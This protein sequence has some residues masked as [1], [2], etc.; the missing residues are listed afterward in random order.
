MNEE[1]K[2][3]RVL[4]IDDNPDD[5]QLVRREV[6]ALFPLADV[7]Q[8]CDMAEFDAALDAGAPDLAVTDL[9]IHWSN[10]GVILSAIKARYPD[11]PV[12][13]FTGTGDED[14]AVELMKAGLNDYVVKSSRQL[15]RLRTSLQ[16]AVEM[17]RSRSALSEREAQLTAMV[18]Q[19]D[20]IVRELHHRVKNNLQTMISLL[21]VRGKQ[22]DEATRQHFDDIAGR[23]SVLGA[24]QSRIYE[25]G[26]LDRVEFRAVLSDLVTTLC[27]LHGH[28][29]IERDFDGPLHLDIGRATPLALVCYELILNAMKHAWP[30]SDRGILKVGI[31]TRTVPPEIAFQDDGVGFVDGSTSKGLG[32]R[33]IRSLAKEACVSIELHSTP[34]SG[35]AVTLKLM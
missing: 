1:A 32:T 20:V 14:I 16:L 2:P 26:T 31:R 34:V 10:G 24:V 5:R 23:I 11:C 9:D 22:V 17:A 3:M 4:I 15:P 21:R 28:T 25:V 30:C 12:V 19:R 7:A 29:K 33:L 35:T 27:S 18:A 13:M 6:E 8:P